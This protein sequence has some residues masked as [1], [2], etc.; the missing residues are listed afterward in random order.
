MKSSLVTATALSGMIACLIMG[1]GANLPL[2]LAPGMGMNAYFTYNVVGYRGTGNVRA[3]ASDCCDKS[4][5]KS[6]PWI[7]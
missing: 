1:L 7:S 4:V 2:A 3:N 6:S 5:V